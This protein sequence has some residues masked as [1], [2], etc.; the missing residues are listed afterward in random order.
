MAGATHPQQIPPWLWPQAAYVHIPFCAHHCCYCDFAVAA[1][2]DHLAERYID[3]LAAELAGLGEPQRVTTLFLGGG[4]PTHL[5]PAQLGRLLD[6]VLHWLRLE[7]GHEFSVEANPATLTPG[8]IAIL[9]DHGVNRLSLGVQSF[10]E[11]TLHVL[12]RDHRAADIRR[13][14]DAAQAQID[15]VSMDLIFGVPGQTPAQW[16]ADLSQALE[17]GV[18]HLSTYGLTYEKGTRL[19]KDREHGL[20]KAL[21]EESELAMYVEA[22][23]R[24]EAAGL[25]QY[26]ISSFARPGRRSRHNQVYWANHAYFGFGLGAARYVEGRRELN[27]RDLEAY[28]SK[29]L[30][31]NAVTM[32]SEKLNGEERAWETIT[33]NLR[34]IEGIDREQFRGQT[35]FEVDDLAGAA[36]GRHVEHGL[37]EDD[38]RRVYLT[39][40]GRCLADGVVSG[41]LAGR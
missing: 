34:R 25:N 21:D 3:A 20:V 28:I 37:L 2:K 40:R 23:D 11:T 18:G 15:N 38:G 10:H 9:A 41:L 32:Q 8:K 26:E 5:A 33:L 17:L 19:W 7:P 4:T 29:S 31:S 14:L 27:T 30:A 12:E 36:I 1:G 35:G 6:V 24:L 13:A 22:M 39:R 16:A